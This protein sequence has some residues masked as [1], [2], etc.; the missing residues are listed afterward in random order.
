M[1][2][3]QTSDLI[4]D[5]DSWLLDNVSET[6]R[7]EQDLEAIG[8]TRLP[9]NDLER[10][11]RALGDLRGLQ[12]D[13]VFWDRWRPSM[14]NHE[15]CALVRHENHTVLKHCRHAI[16]IPILQLLVHCARVKPC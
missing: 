4:A 5:I 11:F 15:A 14:L 6:D 2:E 1:G 7:L 12:A 16:T 3:K 8:R 10:M 9:A 13:Q